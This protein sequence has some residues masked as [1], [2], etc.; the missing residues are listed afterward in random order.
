MIVN[1]MPAAPK[2][3]P[4]KRFN[5]EIQVIYRSEPVTVSN[6]DRKRAVKYSIFGLLLALGST[7][8]LATAQVQPPAGLP[9]APVVDA[10]AGPVQGLK[11]KGVYEY[12]GIPYA[13]PPVGPLRWQPPQPYPSWSQVREATQFG[14]TC[15]QITTTGV[16]ATPS[17]HEDC[18][19][20]NVFTPDLHPSH[21][22]PVMVW[23]HGGGNYDGESND[24]D[25][26][27]LATQG[28]EIVVTLN[29]RTG[30]LGF[31][32]A[33]AL[34]SE[35]HLFANYGLLDQQ[36]VLKWVQ[37]NIAAFG[38]DPKRVALTGQSSGS[39]D[40]A[41][42]VVS[43]LAE[44]LFNRAIFESVLFDS[45]PLP[46]AEQIG[47]GV[48]VALGCGPGATPAVAACLRGLPVEQ[49]LNVQGTVQMNG[50]YVSP[51]PI[52]DG[53]IV[54][55]QGVFSAFASGRFTHMPIMSGFVHDEE[56]FFD[57]PQ[58][59]FSGKP[60][61]VADVTNYAQVTYGTNAT[62]VL[63]AFPLSSYATPQLA[64]DAIGTPFF[65][66]PQYNINKVISSQVPFYAYEFND[67]TAPFYYPPL[68]QFQ[69]L[70]YHTGDIQYLFPLYHGSTAGIAHP[71]N[72][73]QTILS[74]EMVALW[75]NFVRTGNP[76][77][78]GNFPWPRYDA[79][80]SSSSFYLSENIPTLS[81]LKDT[82]VSQE[83][84]CDFFTPL[85]QF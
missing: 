36:L 10:P 23:V 85:I 31:L 48:S 44:G 65:A 75:T 54:P 82:T 70:A 24:Y 63:D 6:L 35:G 71:L 13:E 58:V 15:A 69:S 73:E 9:L 5:R 7:S 21:D 22:L 4:V 2:L 72:L 80:R 67:K 56:N 66:C 41:A 60:I 18:L 47:T 34:D 19:Y 32:A 26:T 25:A 11:F 30:F 45:L 52:S 14:P 84:S 20:V 77:R 12:L 29:Y 50:P 55:S 37:K 81:L 78:F 76:N 42:N 57:A 33:P 28:H 49:I 40:T 43:P 68:P 16:F 83:H 64:Q 61:S 59:Y 38:G 8:Q 51:L 74:D 3:N 79:S 39:Y 53:T 46:V 62:K 1:V 17:V 27:K